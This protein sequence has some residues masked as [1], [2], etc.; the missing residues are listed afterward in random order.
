MCSALWGLLEQKSDL[1]TPIL[2]LLA[3]F[4]TRRSSPGR[5]AYR[6]EIWTLSFSYFLAVELWFS[7]VLI[8]LVGPNLISQDLRYNA[9][10][11]YFSRPLRRIDYF[12]RQAGRDRRAAWAR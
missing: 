6:V 12:A 9:L 4:S 8:L 1:I 5:G 3:A 2:P 7:M 10:P 11:L